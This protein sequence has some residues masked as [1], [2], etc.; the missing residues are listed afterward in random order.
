MLRGAVGL[1]FSV[2]A[3]NGA[4]A[5]TPAPAPHAAP[6]APAPLVASAPAPV[7]SAP[8]LAPPPAFEAGAAAPRPAPSA[9]VPPDMLP[10]PGGEFTMGAD[11]IGER[12]EQP[13]HR[14]TIA[15]FLL[16]RTE[17]TN[18]E[19][20]ACVEAKRCKPY[21]DGVAKSMKAGEDRRFRGPDQP[22]VGVS[23]FDAKS[24]CEWRGKRLPRE[25]EWERAA[26]GDGR[27][28]P[29][30]D[31]APDPKLHG[32][33]AGCNGG[34]TVP[35]GSF[36]ESKG[37]YGHLDLAGNVWEWIED[38]YDPV[39]YTRAGAARGEPGSCEQILETQDSL[40]KNGQQGFTG[41]NPIPTECERVL[42]GGAFN[43]AAP[44]LRVSNRVHHP[45]G[46]RI[47]V[48]GFRCAKDR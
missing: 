10:V 43:Y 13:A 38:L 17:V 42:R 47:L 31:A 11:G 19:Y 3:C 2:A 4:S 8:A 16:D 33:F 24:Y 35:V 28:Y 5:T 26:R 15:G 22:V 1:L 21:R 18:A 40:R 36:P 23:W 34:T 41:S 20:L 45:G 25:A 29:W 48:A 39:A 27:K 14:V 6:V 37:P 30:G 12:D 46:W 9:A 32:C 44:G 7:A